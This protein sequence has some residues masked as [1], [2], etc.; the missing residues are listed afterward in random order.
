MN[1]EENGA[2]EQPNIV[3][4]KQV[5]SNILNGIH[6]ILLAVIAVGIWVLVAQNRHS[7]TQDVYVVN[8]ID[9]NVENTVDVN[10]D[11]VLGRP[12][13]CRRSYTIDGKEYQAIDVYDRSRW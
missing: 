7:G 1:P 6:N 10:L 13:G 9:A 12:V 2:V 4:K 3:E 5:K 11:E 8:T